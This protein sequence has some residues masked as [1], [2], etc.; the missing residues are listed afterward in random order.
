MIVGAGTW[1]ESEQSL[2]I[3]RDRRK[4]NKQTK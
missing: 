4:E 1:N 3:Y 2:Q